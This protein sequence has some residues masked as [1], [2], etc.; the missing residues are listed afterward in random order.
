ML[1]TKNSLVF[2]YQMHF[3]MLKVQF[4]W[5]PWTRIWI[6]KW[7][8]PVDCYKLI[9]DSQKLTARSCR[10]LLSG[11]EI[12]RQ[13]EFSVDKCNVLHMKEV[14]LNKDDG[15]KISIMTSVAISWIP[16]TL[17]IRKHI[18]NSKNRKFGEE[19]MIWI[20]FKPNKMR[21]LQPWK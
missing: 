3:P 19:G 14:F 12:K 8:F 2:N 10:V 13:V 21:S 5:M 15:F 11:W 6:E 4:C 1:L 16:V 20:S 9:Q 18:M 7:Q 17:A